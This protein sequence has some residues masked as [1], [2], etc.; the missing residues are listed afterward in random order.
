MKISIFVFLLVCFCSTL[1]TAQNDSANSSY[2][3]SNIEDIRRAIEYL[4]GLNQSNPGDSFTRQELAKAYNFYAI[5][6]ANRGELDNAIDYM[7][8]AYDLSVGSQQYSDSLSMLYTKRGYSYYESKQIDKARI[9]L[10]NAIKFSN[11]NTLALIGLG[12]IYYADKNFDEARNCLM[13]ASFIEPSNKDIS[14]RLEQL[15]KEIGVGGL[16]KKRETQNFVFMFESNLNEISF[17]NIENILNEVYVKI[18]QDF[19]YFPSY[20]VVVQIYS[21]EKY[22]KEIGPVDTSIGVYDGRIKLPA[23]LSGQTQNYRRIVYHEYVHALVFD[24]SGNR[25]PRWLHEGLAT[26][27]DPGFIPDWQLLYGLYDTNSLIGLSDLDRCLLDLG[28]MRNAAIAYNESCAIVKYFLSRNN[29]WHMKKILLDLKS[30][31]DINQAFKKE[32]SMDTNQLFNNWKEE[33]LRNKLL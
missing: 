28:N 15:D 31:M 6:L 7:G 23:Y 27:E 2:S 3:S 16:F 33:I 11:K 26:C 13:R 24:L 19:N 22:S 10:N 18:G 9:D 8:R 20:K 1:C 5:Q 25:C 12:N 29:F 4:S 21:S 17:G 30:G 14:S 32:A